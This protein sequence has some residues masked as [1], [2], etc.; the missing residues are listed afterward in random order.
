[1]L[2]TCP[3]LRILATSGEALGVD[4]EVRWLVPSLGLPSLDALA[5]P[6]DDPDR[7]KVS[8]SEAVRL[9]VDHRLWNA[10]RHATRTELQDLFPSETGSPGRRCR[11]DAANLLSD[12]TYQPP[13]ASQC[14]IRHG[15]PTPERD[16]CSGTWSGDGAIRGSSS[17]D[18]SSGH[19]RP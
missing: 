1:V 10:E 9:F 5:T 6:A 12:P 13:C 16:A 7:Q 4:G 3:G 18:T 14:R 19:C 11:A 17:R 2:L 8:E 15:L